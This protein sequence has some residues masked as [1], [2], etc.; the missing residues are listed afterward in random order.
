M[1]FHQT[2]LPGVMLIE[3]TV[4]ADARGFFQETW[5]ARSFAGAGLPVAF[6]QD[7]HSRSARHVLRGLHH[8]LD[9]PQGKLVRVASG[10][11]FDVAVDIRDDSPTFGAWT[12][13]VLSAA[14]HRMLWIPPGFAH[15]FL[16]LADDTDLLYKCTSF[17]SPRTERS[18]AWDDP[19]I[20]I[21]WPLDG[22][23]PSLSPKDAAAA[24]LRDHA[25]SDSARLGRDQGLFAGEAIIERSGPV[26]HV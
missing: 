15:G 1:K 2:E 7:N 3:P 6:V 13:H 24:P 4:F 23:T 12:G 21:R 5:N 14:N 20:G 11:A 17:Y 18:V 26:I 22:A 10:A 16:S 25:A 19:D 9:Q 8:Q